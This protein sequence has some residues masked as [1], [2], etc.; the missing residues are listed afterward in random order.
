M[1]D[2]VL[3][4]PDRVVGYRRSMLVLIVHMMDLATFLWVV[5]LIG[6]IGEANPLAVLVYDNFGAAGAIGFKVLG[7]LGLAA[8]A[9]GSNLRFWLALAPGAIGFMSNTLSALLILVNT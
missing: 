9:Y 5:S 1:I 8:L 2:R 3:S 7:A 4:T 6:I